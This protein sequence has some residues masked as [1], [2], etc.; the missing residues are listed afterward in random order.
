[1]HSKLALSQ[2]KL[3]DS[4]LRL[5]ISSHAN[6]RVKVVNS[7]IHWQLMSGERNL[8]AVQ[9]LTLLAAIARA[10]HNHAPL[11][12]ASLASIDNDRSLEFAQFELYF[13]KPV[14]KVKSSQNPLA[15]FAIEEDQFV[16]RCAPLDTDLCQVT[17][18]AMVADS[19]QLIL[20][21][22]GDLRKYFHASLPLEGRGERSFRAFGA[23][24]E[25]GAERIFEGIF[26]EEELRA[27]YEKKVK[28]YVGAMNQKISSLTAR[29]SQM[30][31]AMEIKKIQSQMEG[32]GWQARGKV[33]CELIAPK[34]DQIHSMREGLR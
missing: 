7:Q 22:R 30:A 34:L 8:L 32:L 20:D 18:E 13:E 21:E 15:L 24:L 17:L 27:L 28:Q 4:L 23:W 10:L 5:G 9:P 31:L 11:L 25:K 12:W 26:S 1:M 3:I 19:L 33:F 29:E 2:Q 16:I 6:S 14:D